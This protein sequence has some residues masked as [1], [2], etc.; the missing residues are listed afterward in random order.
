MA[1]DLMEA[2]SGQWPRL[3]IELAGL[4]PEQLQ[5]RHQPCPAC[6][7]TDRYRWDRDDGPGGW[8][9][10]Q[11]G[12]RER[13]GG[14]GSGMDL[15]LRLT[16]WD[17]ATAARRI[18]AQLGLRQTGGSGP[19]PAP[20][21]SGHPAA[22]HQASEHRSPGLPALRLVV[23]DGDHPPL[24]AGS[25]YAYSPSQRVSR[26]DRPG[27]KVFYANH[28]TDEGWQRG[29]GPDPWPMYQWPAL[30]QASGR[31]LIELEG[32]KCADL[33]IAAGFLATTQP[34]HAHRTAQILERYRALRQAGVAGIVYIS[35]HDEQGLKRALQVIKAATETALPLLHLPA[36]ELWAALPAGGSIDDAPGSIQERI[37]VILRAARAAHRWMNHAAV[38]CSAA[39]AIPGLTPGATAAPRAAHAT[40]ERPFLCLGFD[41]DGYYYQPRSTGQVVRLASSS[42]GG[43][44]LCRLAPIAYWETLFPSKTGVNWTAAASDLFTQQAAVG[45]FDLECLRGRGAWADEGQSVLH[46]GDRLVVDGRSQPITQPFCSRFHYQRGAAIHGPGDATPMSDQEA[47]V[48]LSIAERF[49]W[50]IPA[51]SLLLAGWVALAPISGA[52]S[53]RPHLWLTAAAGS[54]KSTLLERFVGVLLGDFALP[55]VG[56]TTEA[57][58]R[59]ALR[60]DALPVVI[61]EAESNEKADQQRI[62][63]ILALARYASSETRASIGKGSA[64]GEVQRFRV[65]SMFLLSSVSTA[66]RQG[67]DRRRFSQLTLRTPDHLQPPARQ[68]HWDELDRDL[69]EQITAETGRRLIA[70]TVVLI[71]MIRQAV[72]VFSRVAAAHFGSQHQGDQYGTLLAGAWALQSSEVPTA[73]QAQALIAGSDWS[74]FQQSIGLPDER[75]CLNRILQYELRVETEDRIHT[76]NVGEL[77]ETVVTPGGLDPVSARHAEDILSRHGM[78]IQEGHLL[79]SN[80][81]EAIARILDGTPWA[82]SWSTILSRLPGA[83][84]TT[85][86]VR[87]KGAGSKARACAIPIDS[88]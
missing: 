26:L 62:Q 65:R 78:R 23:L 51:S 53:W 41:G 67:A 57:F 18:E 12:G 9:C 32:E 17:F 56:N 66:L 59:Q 13:S 87:F 55:V 85:N 82:S 77:V 46:L 35:D 14:G 34:G 30:L 69:E 49:H 19:G 52:L 3:L 43:M 38:D 16:G 60:S 72:R 22:G 37:S 58:I 27:G 88:L 7:G 84:P 64:A 24:P 4:S 74:T 11:C 73:E 54:G 47:F 2:A 61:D 68:R 10:N 81:A 29:A 42:H 5:D 48:V 83:Q 39:P 28:R 80:T 36:A 70:R 20:P 63:Q 71:P 40:G 31:W 8:F 25:P 45:I 79:V 76:R 44:N 15:L 21:A 75:R 6:G 33:V 50:D 1:G 86:S